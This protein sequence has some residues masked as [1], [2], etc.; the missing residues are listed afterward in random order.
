MEMQHVANLIARLRK[1]KGL[2]QKQFAQQFGISDKSVSKWERAETMPD[3]ALLPEIAAFFGITVDELLQGETKQNTIS[4]CTEDKHISAAAFAKTRTKCGIG[5]G[6]IDLWLVIAI[7]VWAVVGMYTDNGWKN[8]A[9]SAAILLYFVGVTVN[10]LYFIRQCD[11]FFQSESKRKRVQ[12]IALAHAVVGAVAGILC[13]DLFIRVE[14]KIAAFAVAFSVL[15]AWGGYIIR[16][17]SWVRTC[18]RYRMVPVLFGIVIAS[19]CLFAPFSVL[20]MQQPVIEYPI[21]VM[22]VCGRSLA[23]FGSVI[24]FFSLLAATA[25]TA[26][27]VC[28]Q[29]PS[30]SIIAAWFAVVV[31]WSI[32]CYVGQSRMIEEYAL[33]F[34]A[35][36]IIKTVFMPL[37]IYGGLAAL[38]TSIV[39][40]WCDSR[41]KNRENG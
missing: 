26:I 33:T 3:I 30:W 25:Y 24:F 11:A 39:M 8:V 41:R 1:E 14:Q 6:I 38:G 20:N 2:T 12:C 22:R 32:V 19:I 29:L 13:S 23:D 35:V 17:I 4:A 36:G 21:T 5:Y 40:T 37:A 7:T 31:I 10:N 18:V 34:E 9:V 15:L 16:E 28:K 27:G